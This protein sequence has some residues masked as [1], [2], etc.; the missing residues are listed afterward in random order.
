MWG[1]RFRVMHYIEIILSIYYK[2]KLC[3]YAS[4]PTGTT[5]PVICDESVPAG[6]AETE[7]PERSPEEPDHMTD[8]LGLTYVA[9]RNCDLERFS[10]K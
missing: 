10:A 8:N 7:D 4:S 2:Y 1:G 6:N 5:Q 3:V 9:V